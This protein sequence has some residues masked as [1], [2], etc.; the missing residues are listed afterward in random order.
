MAVISSDFHGNISKCLRFLSYKPDEVHVFAGDAVDSFNETPEDQ[1][2][3]LQM[4]IESKAIL[5][6]GNHELSYHPAYRISCSGKHQHGLDNFPQYM[7]DTRW[8]VAAFVDW[9]LVTHAGLTDTF[10]GGFKSAT[11]LVKALNKSFTNGSNDA[12]FDVGMCRGGNQVA[13]GPFWY[14][15]RYDYLRLSKRF[16]QVFGH[17]SLNEPWQESGENYHHVCINSKD[18]NNDLWVFDTHLKK[19]VYL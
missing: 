9:Y 16:N 15:F 19:V 18:T 3:C 7:E 1:E 8:K 2:K 14:D 5:L 17:C 12:L 11:N 10:V 6:Y 13:G 4:L